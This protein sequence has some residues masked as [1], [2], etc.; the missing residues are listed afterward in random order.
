MHLILLVLTVRHER[1]GAAVRRPPGQKVVVVAEGELARFATARS[2]HEQVTY[3][4]VVFQ[5]STLH[6]IDDVFPVEREPRITD[7]SDREDVFSAQG[8]AGCRHDGA[9][10]KTRKE[11]QNPSRISRRPGVGARPGRPR[12]SLL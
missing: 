4:L 6:G 7:E 11:K 2:D 1:N 5:F 10:S 8:G 3:I 9:S 12:K